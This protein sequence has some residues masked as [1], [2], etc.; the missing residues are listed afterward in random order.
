MPLPG[1]ITC[2][3]VLAAAALATAACGAD[4]S[5][6]AAGGEPSV[7]AGT[8]LY[9]VD[10]NT[11]DYSANF[12]PGTLNGVRATLPGGKVGDEFRQRILAINSNVKDFT[13]AP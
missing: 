2:I 7:K 13:Y 9:F 5:P 11:A 1:R 10:G 12:E 3:A 6:T 4:S 8:Q